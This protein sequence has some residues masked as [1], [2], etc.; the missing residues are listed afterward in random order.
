MRRRGNRTNRR[1]T[2]R[3]KEENQHQTQPIYDAGSRNR[4]RDTLVGGEP[5]SPLRRSCSPEHALLPQQ[6][7]GWASWAYFR[8]VFRRKC[9]TPRMIQTIDM[10][11]VMADDANYDQK[12]PGKK[13][14]LQ[15]SSMKVSSCEIEEN[16][17]AWC[18]FLIILNISST[19]FWGNY[20]VIPEKSSSGRPFMKLLVNAF[21]PSKN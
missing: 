2:S 13:K 16:F 1:K 18:L 5:L 20:G 8:K 11:T 21:T 9:R 17:F 14:I 19:K 7:G 12:L 6:S 15:I 4:T 3:S 10:V